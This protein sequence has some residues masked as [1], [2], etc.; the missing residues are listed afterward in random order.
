M[1]IE[2]SDDLKILLSKLPEDARRSLPMIL[3]PMQKY[4]D[5]SEKLFRKYGIGPENT[6]DTRRTF[7]DHV[8]RVDLLLDGQ[9]QLDQVLN[10]LKS[11][12][13]G[14]LTIAPPAPGYYVSLAGNDQILE[15][16][17]ERQYPTLDASQREQFSSDTS[18]NVASVANGSS[19][20]LTS[21]NDGGQSNLEGSTRRVF[22]PMIELLHSTCLR[23]IR[24]VQKQ[25][26]N[27]RIAFQPIGDRLAI[28][29][30]GLFNGQVTLDQALD[31]KSAARQLL[32]KNIA[33]ILADIAIIL[34]KSVCAFIR[35]LVI[36]RS[37]FLI[38]DL[39][40]GFIAVEKTG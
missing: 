28:W 36:R 40:V 32:R 33:G 16:S 19:A 20:R 3:A 8:R 1:A 12:N 29:G 26:P 38:S 35:V 18:Q 22:R 21:H 4:G 6:A 11:C 30:S 2:T 9:R 15:T 5:L 17:D 23:I 13:D 39:A 31:A 24:L 7:K 37:E 27:H 10:T 25:Y 14:L 34:S